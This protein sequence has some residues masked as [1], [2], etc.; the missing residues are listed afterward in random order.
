MKRV[1]SP[2]SLRCSNHVDKMITVETE[3]RL[4]LLYE[5]KFDLKVTQVARLINAVFGEDALSEWKAQFWCSKSRTGKE[6]LEDEARSRRSKALDEE[7]AR[8][9][10]EADPS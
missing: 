8:E 5:Y 2:V 6:S 10:T 4:T 3:I 7:E 1:F 9:I